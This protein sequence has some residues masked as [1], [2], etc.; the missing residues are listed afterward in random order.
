MIAKKK[1]K[2]ILSEISSNERTMNFNY[3]I[4][5]SEAQFIFAFW[6]DSNTEIFQWKNRQEIL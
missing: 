1:R 2:E 3:N 6:S 5:L 4:L